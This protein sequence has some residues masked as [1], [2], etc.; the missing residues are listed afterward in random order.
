MESGDPSGEAGEAFKVSRHQPDLEVCPLLGNS[1]ASTRSGK[2][3]GSCDKD[4][5]SFSVVKEALGA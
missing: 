2:P 1:P 4:P 3:R 5:G